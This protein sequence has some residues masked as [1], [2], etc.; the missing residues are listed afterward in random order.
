MSRRAKITRRKFIGIAV[1][2][3]AASPMVSCTGLMS[4]W[5]FLSGAE[6]H[7]LGAICERLI[8]A[9]Q[10]AGAAWA[11]VVNFVDR[12]LAGP[13][14]KSRLSY[15]QGLAGTDQTSQILFG[16]RF[17]ELD[18][19]Q[20]DEI[21]RML[22]KG[23]APGDAWKRLSAERFFDLVLTHTMQ[24]FYGDPRHGGNREAVSWRMLSLP[25][26]P[27]RGRVRY[28]LSRPGTP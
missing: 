7:T 12:Q 27:I 15:R 22:E 28:D 11:G 10:Y 16:W 26:P 17:A 2:A 4:P 8:P 13:Y 6:A 25:N 3:A 21:L 20:Q 9:D 18:A 24:G 14:K 23:R 19:R 5:R 1:T